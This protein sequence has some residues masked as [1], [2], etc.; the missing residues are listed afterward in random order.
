MAVVQANN[1]LED[2][3]QLES[4]SLSNYD[5]GPYGTFIGVYDGHGGPETT[6]FVNDHLFYH[7][8]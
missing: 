2:H 6:R 5:S 8:K 3:S 4:G 1:L 7:L